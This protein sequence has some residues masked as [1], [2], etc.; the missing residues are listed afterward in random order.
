LKKYPKKFRNKVLE[1]LELEK[2]KKNGLGI[3]KGIGEFRE[4]ERKEMMRRLG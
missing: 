3:F 2:V 1:R 4:K